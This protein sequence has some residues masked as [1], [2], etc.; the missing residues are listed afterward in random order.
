[1]FSSFKF[2][3]FAVFP[4]P[5]PFPGLAAV[6]QMSLNCLNPAPLP[7]EKQSPYPATLFIL[8]SSLLFRHLKSL[9]DSHSFSRDFLRRPCVVAG[10]SILILLLT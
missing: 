7:S 8:Y 10:F 3:A 9:S 1:M 2:Q 5:G 4:L 6:L